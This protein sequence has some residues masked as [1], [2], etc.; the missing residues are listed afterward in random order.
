MLTPEQAAVANSMSDRGDALRDA[1]NWQQSGWPDWELYHP[2]FEATGGA[3]V[4]GMA[5]AKERVR[6][7]VSEN[8]ATVF[9]GDPA[10][11]GLVSPLPNNQQTARERHQQEVHC[12][13]LP[14]SLLAGMVEAQR[15]RDASFA[16]TSLEA[17]E[18]TK[19]P[20]VVI[21]GTGHARKDW[22][23]PAAL[24][25]AAPNTTVISVGQLEK[26]A[27]DSET[28]E[29]QLYDIRLIADAVDREDPC[30]SMMQ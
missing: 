12:N 4:Y 14:T 8:A 20:V 24:A 11:F 1:L 25:R 23:I 17:L 29:I 5:L 2:V 30:K 3:R 26:H 15:L 22:G 21:T 6:E 13:M 9:D 28:S 10:A 16:Q 7:A 27:Q 18:H 19:G